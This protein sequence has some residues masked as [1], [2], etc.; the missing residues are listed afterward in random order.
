VSAP[1]NTVDYYWPEAGPEAEA[2]GQ[3]GAGGPGR[4][5]VSEEQSWQ[6]WQEWHDWGPPPELHPDHPS[7]PVPRIQVSADYRPDP[8]SD[9]YAPGGPYGPDRGPATGV[10]GNGPDLDG[11][12]LWMAGQVL[13][14]ADDQAA[15]IA[16]EARQYAAAVRE[17]A[18][19]EAAAITQ[20]AA[21]RANAITQ[22]AASQADAIT[23]QAATRADV[24]T[25]QA[26]G[27]AVAIRE[28]AEREAAEL[29]ASLIS[30][31]G[32]LG[33]VAAYITEN[34]GA[35]PAPA[36]LLAL[37]GVETTRPGD[38]SPPPA[39]M[40]AEPD[41]GPARPRARPEKPDPRRGTRPAGPAAP[42]TKPATRPA[43][44]PDSTPQKRPR[45][46]QAM[47]IASFATAA[48]VL[49]S[50]TAGAAEIGM[51]GFKFFVFREGG[52]GQTQGNETDQNFLARQAAA[53]HHVPAP[54]GR[55]HKRPHQTPAKHTR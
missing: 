15:Q 51:H 1:L 2:Y 31:S 46:Y 35:P 21:N 53:T 4:V 41:T 16:G 29:R 8:R 12:S 18:E 55:H 36:A 34:L 42:A 25:Q 33:R 11:D 6:E 9:P 20:L 50:I 37:P 17:A 27:Q 44:A 40:P 26:A 14:L 48:V 47:R 38:W 43:S 13:T 39:V 49:A 24:I 19:R 10:F 23:Q 3:A 54:K 32:E 30:M 7:A 28:A 52:V 5:A 45:Q 22:Q